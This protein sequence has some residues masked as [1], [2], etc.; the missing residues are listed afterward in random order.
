MVLPAL[1][2]QAQ[3]LLPLLLA[4]LVFEAALSRQPVPASSVPLNLGVSVLYWVAHYTLNVTVAFYVVTAVS[5]LPGAPLF[6][7]PVETSAVGVL[8]EA[9]LLLFVHDFFF[10]WLHRAQHA[11]P[12]LWAQHALHHAD[13]TMN[14]TTAWRHHWTESLLQTVAILAP[15]V[16]LCTTDI[17]VVVTLA[18]L[19]DSI[20]LFIHTNV[21]L[22]LGRL[23]RV[24]M[25]PAWHRVHHSPERQHWDRNFAGA[26]S[27]FD[28][29]FG[30]HYVPAPEEVPPTGLHHREQA[31]SLWGAAIFPIL[32]WRSMRTRAGSLRDPVGA[33]RAAGDS[34]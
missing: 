12:I 1:L 8:A 27:L 32:M 19:S 33:D 24:L 31:R 14:A 25:N 29:L 5:R 4:A 13:E 7:L 17:R 22:R 15:A 6:A 3:Y 18:V 11:I 2:S 28:V 9:V 16:Y 34:V 21:P 20:A 26:F 30:T 10:Y 23:D